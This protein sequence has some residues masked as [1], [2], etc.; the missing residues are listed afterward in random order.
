MII[1]N[2]SHPL[3]QSQLDQITDLVDQPITDVKQIPTHLSNGQ[4]LGPQVIDLVKKAELSGED[5]QTRPLL[6]NPPALNYIAVA[7][8]AEIHGRCGYFPP[9][10]RI[11]PV[12]DGV[13]RRYEVAE[14]IDL[15]QLRDAA[16]RNRTLDVKIK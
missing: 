3:T 15:Q 16:R 5:W 6:I 1:L 8:L 13:P 4:P 9:V 2:Y 10:I 7:L 11:R 14:I 12:E